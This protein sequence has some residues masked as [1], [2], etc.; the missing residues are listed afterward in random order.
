MDLETIT[1]I[2]EKTNLEYIKDNKFK[3]DLNILY[4]RK[5]HGFCYYCLE[6]FDDERILSNKC[7]I[8]HLR[9]NKIIG[10]RTQE[11]LNSFLN[12]AEWDESFNLSVNN[13]IKELNIKY[14][15]TIE[16]NYFNKEFKI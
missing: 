3:L 1:K 11:N 6:E 4:L 13:K 10:K 16:E 5:I 9:S 7:D 2:E 15:L 14:N 8:I 12:E